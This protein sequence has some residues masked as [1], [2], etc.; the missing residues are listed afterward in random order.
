MLCYLVERVADGKL[1]WTGYA[2]NEIDA[3]NRADSS[4]EA[5]TEFA[6]TYEYDRSKV[7]DGVYYVYTVPDALEWQAA[8]L[9]YE[10]VGIFGKPALIYTKRA[11]P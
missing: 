2:T 6:F 8:H 4:A 10:D 3:A 7:K 5:K 1:M 11:N 9:W